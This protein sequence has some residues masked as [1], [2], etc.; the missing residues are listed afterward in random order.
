MSKT[1]FRIGDRV[2]PTVQ[3]DEL[4][5]VIG[6]GTSTLPDRAP[7]V[8]VRFDRE[9]L[10]YGCEGPQAGQWVEE[11]YLTAV[12]TLYAENLNDA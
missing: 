10:N 4:G 12:E 1:N 9:G 8:Q 11:Q 2:H 6:I 5:T 7:M 3:P